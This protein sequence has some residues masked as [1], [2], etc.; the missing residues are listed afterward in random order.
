M[1]MVVVVGHC[2]VLKSD[3]SI[4][5]FFE[6]KIRPVLA[7]SCFGCHSRLKSE[8]ELRVDSRAGLIKGG[9][10]RLARVTH[11][12]EPAFRAFERPRE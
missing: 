3:D 7:K 4:E 6:L 9:E 11:N 1:L 12:C 2:S 8:G 10:R 5:D